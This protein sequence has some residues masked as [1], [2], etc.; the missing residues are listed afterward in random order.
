MTSETRSA[1]QN[2]VTSTRLCA[3][4]DWSSD[5]PRRLAHTQRWI[6]NRNGI[7]KG[8]ERP[9]NISH[10]VLFDLRDADSSKND[11]FHQYGILRDDYIPKPAY[12]TFKKLIQELG[13]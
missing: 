1:I 3:A 11:L 13:I 10:Y 7:S 5:D 9:T 8:S 2:S 6:A 12:A 4:F